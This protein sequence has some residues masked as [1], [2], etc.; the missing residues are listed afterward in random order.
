[1]YTAAFARAEHPLA[2]SWIVRVTVVGTPA[3][4][5]V[6]VPK[7]D[8]MSLRTMPLS[9]STFGPFD[10][11]PGYGPA[12]SSLIGV[13]VAADAVSAD[14]VV[15]SVTDAMV[16]VDS[17][18]TVVAPVVAAVLPAAAVVWEAVLSLPH[19]ASANKVLPASIFRT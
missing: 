15:A 3:A 10:P 9:V 4:T 12:V 5:V 19:A 6:E 13:H 7:L 11:S 18:V 17:E 8:V 1:M 2:V 16:V 14:A